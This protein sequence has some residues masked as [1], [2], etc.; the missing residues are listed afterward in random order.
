MKKKL[1]LLGADNS[2][3]D[4]IKYAHSKGIYTIVTDNRPP[5]ASEAKQLSDE[6]WM[7]NITEIDELDKKCREEKITGV[8]AGN[9][10]FCLDCCKKL[11]ERLGLP[12]YASDAGWRASRDKLFYKEVCRECGI[13]TPRLFELDESFR[14]EDISR[15]DYPVIVKPSDSCAQQGLSLVTSV[16]DLKE[17]FNLALQFSDSKKIIVEEYI[18]GDEVFIFCFIHDGIVTLLAV[19]EDMA[20]TDING[21][22]NFGFGLHKSRYLPL[23]NETLMPRLQKVAEKLGCRDGACVV[24]GIFRDNEFYS[25]EFGYR[26]DGIRSWRHLSKSCGINQLELMVDLALGIRPDEN[27]WNNMVPEENRRLS[28]GYVIWAKPGRVARAEGQDMLNERDDI[29]ILLDNFKAG[30][31]ILPN[32]NMRSIAYDITI[33]GDS[34]EDL[35]CKVKEIN[36]FLH[37]YDPQGRDLLIYLDFSL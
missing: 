31:E 30:S 2:A 6:Q 15:I 10:E 22:Q 18:S 19:S 11:C 4:A 27:I 37:L 32:D 17:A 5:A 7:I 20:A 26:L 8:Y 29:V 25:L 9:H 36:Q 34:Y 23:I 21:R 13:S 35:S 28:I 12:F 14:K 16:E 1:L 24:Q 33:Y 3:V